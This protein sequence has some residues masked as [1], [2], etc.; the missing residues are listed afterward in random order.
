MQPYT[1]E[2]LCTLCNRIEQQLASLR[3]HKANLDR[4][5]AVT[6]D[7][8]IAGQAILATLQAITG[9]AY[10]AETVPVDLDP[11]S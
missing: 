7:N 5:L 1:P 8:I 6:R 4:D 11:C 3:Q 9:Q 2:Q 10:D